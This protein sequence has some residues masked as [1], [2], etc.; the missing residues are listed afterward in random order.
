MGQI[1]KSLAS[2]SLSVNT[3]TAARNFDSI[4]MKFFTGIWGPKSKIEFVWDKNLT[5]PSP[6]LPQFLKEIASWPMD[7]SKQYNSFPVKDTCVLCLPTPLIFAP[8]D[9]CCHSNHSKVAKF[10]ITANGDFKAV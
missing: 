9:P 8:I 10:V 5:T 3:P 4:L 6:I 1:I 7:T 2:V